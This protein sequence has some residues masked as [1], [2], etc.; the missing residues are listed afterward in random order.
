[1]EPLIKD[2]PRKGQP[3]YK[4]HLYAIAIHF[5]LPKRGQP[6]YK[7]DKWLI[8]KCPLLRDSTVIC[9]YYMY[10]TCTIV[11]I[12]MEV[13]VIVL[14]WQKS[15]NIVSFFTDNLIFTIIEP[16]KQFEIVFRMIDVDGSDSIDL[17]EFEEV[18]SYWL[19]Y[20]CITLGTYMYKVTV[21]QW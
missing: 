11:N 6:P 13:V 17:K 9:M 19:T 10:C 1:M 12:N 18:N 16:R 20:V 4:G 3:L 8:P 5:Q 21:I 15:Y 7:R 2:P 14:C